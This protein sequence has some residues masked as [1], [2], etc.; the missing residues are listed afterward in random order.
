MAHHSQR[1]D[2]GRLADHLADRGRVDAE[3]LRGLLE[4]SSTGCQ[5]LPQALVEGG[6][7]SDWDLAKSVCEVFQLAFVPIEVATPNPELIQLFDPA[8]LLKHGLVPL[9]Q[10]G[11]TVTVIMPGLVEADTLGE[12]A[13]ASDLTI[14][15]VVGTIQGNQAWLAQQIKTTEG[16]SSEWGSLF[17]EG[18]AAVKAAL[19]PADPLETPG[20]ALPVPAPTKA[21]ISRA[22]L[23][24]DEGLSLPP[25]PAFEPKGNNLPVGERPSGGE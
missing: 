13:A 9:V 3:V 16:E 21:S 2:F 7:L 11:A 25:A 17:D 10:F 1:L 6:F 12:L 4:A 18:D 5:P 15:P 23:M 20:G 8:T 24:G 22:H 14:Q 19:D